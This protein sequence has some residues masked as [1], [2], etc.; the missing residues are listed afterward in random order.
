MHHLRWSWRLHNLFRPSRRSI[1]N[2]SK[3]RSGRSVDCRMQM[4]W[5]LIQDFLC[6]KSLLEQVRHSRE[7]FQDSIAECND[8][9]MAANTNSWSRIISHFATLPAL[10]FRI[11]LLLKIRLVDALVIWASIRKCF[12]IHLLRVWNVVAISI[13]RSKTA[14]AVWRAWK[15]QR[16]CLYSK[17]YVSTYLASWPPNSIFDICPDSD[18]TLLDFNQLTSSSSIWSSCGPSLDSADCVADLGF[19]AP[20]GTGT[21]YNL[22][23]LPA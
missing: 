19:E 14:V 11:D 1:C 16:T 18:P 21:L 20:I 10:L 22:T 2:L 3:G 4:F 7:S 9:S 23:N 15:S 12:S 8:R 5:L 17:G 6:R 13:I